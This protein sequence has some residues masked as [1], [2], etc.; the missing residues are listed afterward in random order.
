MQTFTAVSLSEKFCLWSACND[1]NN[2]KT[3]EITLKK[4]V[5]GNLHFGP[6]LRQSAFYSWSAVCSL[7]F[8]LTDLYFMSSVSDILLDIL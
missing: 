1:G 3:I 4:S 8:T 2:L 5:V 7:H 6:G